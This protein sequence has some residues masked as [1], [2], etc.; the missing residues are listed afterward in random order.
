MTPLIGLLSSALIF[1][2]YLKSLFKLFI[3]IGRLPLLAH[4]FTSSCSSRVVILWIILWPIEGSIWFSTRVSNVINV[5]SFNRVLISCM[6]QLID[7]LY[8]VIFSG[9]VVKECIISNLCFD[10]F[11]LSLRRALSAEPTSGS[12]GSFASLR[13]NSSIYL[14]L[15]CGFALFLIFDDFWHG[16]CGSFLMGFFQWQLCFLWYT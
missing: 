3:S 14:E 11:H 15:I 2:A 7:F 6:E 10:P 13:V 9:C 12:H 5:D 4:E 16:V 8:G 1:C